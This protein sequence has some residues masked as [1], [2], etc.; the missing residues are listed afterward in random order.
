[1]KRYTIFLSLLFAFLAITP[2]CA[3]DLNKYKYVVVLRNFPSPELDRVT[4]IAV[5][6][7]YVA[8]EHEIERRFSNMGFTVLTNTKDIGDDYR[9]VLYIPWGWGIP[10]TGDIWIGLNNVFG[11]S[12]I[13]TLY[14]SKYDSY[15]DEKRISKTV[16]N[17]FK[18]L[19]NY[20]YHFQPWTIIKDQPILSISSWSEDSICSYF[21]STK[22][23]P[24]EGIYK[25][26][27]KP[28]LYLK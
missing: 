19:E 3:Q 17:A 20:D 1:M 26:Y 9:Y 22:I 8:T 23:S 12:S 7:F 18:E 2:V 10:S 4:Q 11:Q 15:S 24:I 5:N 16:G 6:D 21:S 25:N 27:D 14:G 28:L 13:L